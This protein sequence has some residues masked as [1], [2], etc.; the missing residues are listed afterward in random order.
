ML[1]SPLVSTNDFDHSWIYACLFLTIIFRKWMNVA[2]FNAGTIEEKIYQRQIS[3]QALSGAV[4]DFSKGSEHIRFSVEELR[5]LFTLHEDSNCV[6]HDLL[7]CSCMGKKDNQGDLFWVAFHT[8][9]TVLVLFFPLSKLQNGWL[10]R[11]L[12]KFGDDGHKSAVKSTMH[13][14]RG[15]ALIAGLWV[16][17]CYFW[18][19][20]LLAGTPIA[21]TG[22]GGFDEQ[23]YDVNILFLYEDLKP[24]SFCANI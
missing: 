17:P 12:K 1:F 3:K 22:I 2:F 19:P 6:T 4:V 10:P 13:I 14:K 15:G 16:P 8:Q 18:S 21:E 7:E 9:D 11:G 5:N 20:T 23:F 24:M